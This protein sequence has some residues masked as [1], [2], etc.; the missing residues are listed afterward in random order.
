MKQGTWG[1]FRYQIGRIDTV[2]ELIRDR[3]QGILIKDAVDEIVKIVKE[4]I[5][6]KIEDHRNKRVE[7]RVIGAVKRPSAED[8]TKSPLQKDEEDAMAKT[9]KEKGI[10]VSVGKSGQ[11]TIKGE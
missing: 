5:Q 3:D 11:K 2:V 1:D 8:L 10:N 6:D 4:V 9:L 7:E